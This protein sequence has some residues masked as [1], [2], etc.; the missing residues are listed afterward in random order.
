MSYLLL[1]HVYP[2]RANFL[3]FC[4]FCH[5]L[6][7]NTYITTLS[8]CLFSF[9]FVYYL[10]VACHATFCPFETLHHPWFV[11]FLVL[12]LYVIF[13]PLFLIFSFFF[14][15]LFIHSN[16]TF[17]LY[18]T[19]FTISFPQFYF[20]NSSS[21]PLAP[22]YF[23]FEAPKK[24]NNKCFFTSLYGTP[25]LYIVVR[26]ANHSPI[27]LGIQSFRIPSYLFLLT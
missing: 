4:S 27:S 5:A 15:F 14:I 12:L 10:L 24:R 1:L 9:S 11:L 2:Y 21:L 19:I 7:S 8:L 26:T 13:V 6:R 20:I 18:I 23:P 25:Y 16:T 17:S 22:I 3:P